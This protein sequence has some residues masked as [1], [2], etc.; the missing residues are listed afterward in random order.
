MDDFVITESTIRFVWQPTVATTIVDAQR[1][2]SVILPGGVFVTRVHSR[3]SDY[4]PAN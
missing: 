3:L 2:P 4:A 1:D